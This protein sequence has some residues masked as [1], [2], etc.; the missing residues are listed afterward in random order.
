MLFDSYDEQVIYFGFWHWVR[1]VHGLPGP[2]G[3]GITWALGGPTVCVDARGIF[4][5]EGGVGAWS[6]GKIGKN[7]LSSCKLH[8]LKANFVPFFICGFMP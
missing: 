7:D 1:Q 8:T 5:S 6:P 4:T 3:G 2:G